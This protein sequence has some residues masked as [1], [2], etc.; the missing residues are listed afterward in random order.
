MDKPRILVVGSALHHPAGLPTVADFAGDDQLLAESRVTVQ[1]ALSSLSQKGLSAVI[2]WAEEESQLAGVIRIRKA[3][4]ELPILL[5]SPDRSPG[6]QSL[7]R[8][9][10]ATRVL[11]PDSDPAKTADQIRDA[12]LSGDLLGELRARLSET[13]RH[14]RDLR[15]LLEENRNLTLSALRSLKRGPRLTFIPLV[16]EGNPDAAFRTVRALEK[17]DVFAPLPILKSRDE[18]LVFLTGLRDPATPGLHLDPTVLLLDADLPQDSSF[19]VLRWVREHPHFA[20][21]PVVLFGN[22]EDLPRVRRAYELGAN[23]FLGRPS[24]LEACVHCFR[25]LKTYWGSFNQGPSSY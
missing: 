8:Q 12:V 9:L 21:L 24:D 11:R 13:A 15:D 6:F 10:G 17:A 4:P 2:C 25:S 3:A 5:L 1:E 14:A 18:T 23:S 20:K 22:P 16:V 19:E 7:A